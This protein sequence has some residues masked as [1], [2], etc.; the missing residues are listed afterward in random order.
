MIFVETV[1]WSSVVP[2]APIWKVKLLPFNNCFPAQL[3]L[4][5]ILSY[6]SLIALNSFCACALSLS[7]KVD[8]DAWMANSLILNKID[9]DSFNAPSAVSISDWASAAFLEATLSPSISA[10]KR[11][12]IAIPAASSFA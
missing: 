6:S 11:V 2:F 10:V 12:D 7:V 9:V 8:V 5:E 4:E 3:V 1:N